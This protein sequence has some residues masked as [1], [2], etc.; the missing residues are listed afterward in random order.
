MEGIVS[1]PI[2]SSAVCPYCNAKLAK[3]PQRKK[4]CPSCGNFIFVRTLPTTR[5]KVL[6]TEAEAR[7]IDEE[8]AQRRRHMRWLD[9]LNA[10]GI[11]KR[12]FAQKK[13]YLSK[14]WGREAPDSG[15]IWTFLNE[16]LEK[17]AKSGNLHR[18]ST[19][20]YM[21]AQ[22]LDEEGKDFF[23]LLV[24]SSKWE[25]MDLKQRGFT[26]V[27]VNT[28]RDTYVC[29][30]CQQ[31]AGRVFSIDDAVRQMPIPCKE[32]THVVHSKPGFCRCRYQPTGDVTRKEMR[33]EL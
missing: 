11:P 26:K 7:R 6:A 16:L 22:F 13:K 28:V 9:F 12:A 24:E 19:L 21:M 25:L 27:E 3:R 20:Y 30:A 31:L 29:P 14:K 33:F 32:C 15:V 17:E 18:L 1:V 5:E 2:Q 23:P 8:W 10:N 4:K